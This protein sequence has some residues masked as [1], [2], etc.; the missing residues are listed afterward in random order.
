MTI[1]DGARK[2]MCR[3]SLFDPNN[4]M[5]IHAAEAMLSGI[6]S[7]RMYA[8]VVNKFG[9]K[10]PCLVHSHLITSEDGDL[11]GI[12]NTWTV[13]PNEITPRSTNMMTRTL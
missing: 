4:N 2:S 13:L 9:C 3:L 10:I 5:V 11:E 8:V 12:T 1:K 7:F 6:N